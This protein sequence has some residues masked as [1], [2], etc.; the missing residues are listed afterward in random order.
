[1]FQKKAPFHKKSILCLANLLTILC[2]TG[3]L[4]ACQNGEKVLENNFQNWEIY[5]G[6]DWIFE[7]G[8]L[9]GTVTDSVGFVMSDAAYTDFK[10]SLEFK[11]DSSINSG[12]YLRCQNREISFTTCYEFNIWDLHPNQD[13]RTGALV[14]MAAPLAHVETI[15]QWNTYEIELKDNELKAWVNGIQTVDLMDTGLHSGYIALQAMGTGKVS[16][17]NIIIHQ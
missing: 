5:G 1:M 15:N 7:N 16:F 2:I 4:F 8:E 17:R 3:L 9:T 13:F 12:I 6:A 10:L 11:P 14:N